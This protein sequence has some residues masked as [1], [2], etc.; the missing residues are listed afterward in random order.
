[1]KEAETSPTVRNSSSERPR[2]Q[3]GL[4]PGA[5]ETRQPRAGVAP[6]GSARRTGRTGTAS[7]RTG[8]REN[9]QRV[10]QLRVEA[11]KNCRTNRQ[12]LLASTVRRARLPGERAPLSTSRSGGGRCRKS[13]PRLGPGSAVSCACDELRTQRAQA[14]SET[15]TPKA[16]RQ[17]NNATNSRARK[18]P[19]GERERRK[20]RREANNAEMARA[21]SQRRPNHAIQGR[22]HLLSNSTERETHP[23][24]P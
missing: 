23:G 4:T 1:M 8:G 21:R 22:E 13:R 18:S 14:G 10:C 11:P 9:G 17:K 16:E 3:L 7:G 2:S 24:S 19:R 12:L 15:R 20:P 6:D 5:P